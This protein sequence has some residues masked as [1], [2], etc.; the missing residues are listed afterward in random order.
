MAGKSV[1]AS[2]CPPVD[3]Q[4]DEMRALPAPGRSERQ[5]P[6]DGS[7]HGELLRAASGSLSKSPPFQKSEG[8]MFPVGSLGDFGNSLLL[9][10]MSTPQASTTSTST[11]TVMQ[12]AFGDAVL[13]V[14]ACRRPLHYLLGLQW[15]QWDVYIKVVM[16][17]RDRSFS[18]KLSRLDEDAIHS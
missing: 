12:V 4:V 6:G 14:R 18:C 11:F 1:R 3:L 2:L 8:E 7:F 5:P 15:E 9:A 17:F 13:F 10:H 16:C